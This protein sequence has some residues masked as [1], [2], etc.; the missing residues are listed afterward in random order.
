MISSNKN[1]EAKYIDE[2]VLQQLVLDTDAEIVPEFIR[3]YIDDTKIR[4][5]L[6]KD[7]IAN[8]NFKVLEFETHTISSSA[9]AHGN[10]K[11]HQLSKTIE[12]H[13]QQDQH[14]QALSCAVELINIADRSF[15]LL[16]QRADKGF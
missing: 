12:D 7:A 1:I 15:E 16:A 5:E 9:A 10:M 11:L 4:I 2:L 8:N 3:F 13:C 6:I 14:I